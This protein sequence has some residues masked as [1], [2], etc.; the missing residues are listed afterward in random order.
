MAAAIVQRPSP[1]S[2]TRPENCCK[3]GSAAS[4]AAVR[5]SSHDDTTLPRRQTSVIAAMSNS[6][7]YCSGCRIGAV[8][9]SCSCACGADVRVLQHVQAFGIR[10]HDAVLDAVVDHLDE[11]AGAVRAAVQVSAF[12]RADGR[13]L[14]AWRRWSG[15]D[16]WRQRGEDRIEMRDDCR[17]AADH[18]AEAALESPDPAARPDVDV[19]DAALAERGAAPDVVGEMRVA[20][21]DQDV[22]SLNMWRQPID[23]LIDHRGGDH[24]PDRARRAQLRDE[25]VDR[26]CRRLAPSFSSGGIAAGLTS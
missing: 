11:V 8:S 7:R 19:V 23:R 18:L 9:A 6:Y 25:L 21:V 16:A 5:S 26:P 20:A 13:A 12:R 15:R 14:A 4:A 10:R 2:E 22:V 1:E 24:H 3:A 17:L